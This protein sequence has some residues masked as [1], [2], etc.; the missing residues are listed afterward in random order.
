[1]YGREHYGAIAGALAMPG[2]LARALGPAL[3]AVLWTAFGG[4]DPVTGILI[5]I[6]ALGAVAFFVA[7]ARAGKGAGVAG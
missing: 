3:A 1:M 2:L 6:A 4:Y 7:T 5:A